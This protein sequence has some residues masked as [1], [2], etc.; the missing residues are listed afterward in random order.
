M[1]QYIN[2]LADKLQISTSDS[3][4]IIWKVFINFCSFVIYIE[5]SLELF[6]VEEFQKDNR[7][8]IF[9]IW[10]IFIL[11]LL[12]IDM[13]I[14]LF[15]EYISNNGII[16]QKPYKKVKYYFRHYF[17]FDLIVIV[18]LFV[19]TFQ[20][21]PFW[22]GFLV[23]FRIPSNLYSDKITE[24]YLIQFQF[25]LLC[26]RILKLL[27]TLLYIF[28]IFACS[29]Y[30]MGLYSISIQEP[31]WLEYSNSVIGNI[32]EMHHVTQYI[33]SY[34]W[35]V[36]TLVS[37]GY[38]EITPMNQYEIIIGD[39]ALV[40]CMFV[41]LYVISTILSFQ[42]DN[43]SYLDENMLSIKQFMIAKRVSKKLY[44]EVSIFLSQ[45][46]IEQSKRDIAIEQVV[47]QRLPNQLKSKLYYEASLKIMKRILWI[48]NNFSNEFIEELSSCVREIYLNANTTISVIDDDD[49]PKIF[50]IDK[51][52]V[53]VIFNEKEINL[54]YR[55][56]TFGNYSFFTQE[57]EQFI[58]Y[59]TKSIVILQYIKLTDFLKTISNHKEDH[60]KFYYIL[61]QVLFEKKYS[62]IQYGCYICTSTNHLSENCQIISIKDQ[63]YEEFYKNPLRNSIQLRKGFIRQ[64]KKHSKWILNRNAIQITHEYPISFDI[65]KRYYSKLLF[66]WHPFSKH[67]QERMNILLKDLLNDSLKQNDIIIMSENK[68][69]N[70]KK[71]SVFSSSNQYLFYWQLFMM[72]VNAIFFIAIP[73][74]IFFWNYYQQFSDQ[75]GFKFIRIIF[76]ILFV[77][78]FIVQLN[79]NFYHEGILVKNRFK[80]AENYLRNDLVFDLIPILVLFYISL[81]DKYVIV[82]LLCLIKLIPFYRFQVYLSDKLKIM[83]QLRQFYMI[84]G[85]LIEILYINHFYGCM[86]YGGSVYMYTYH[87]NSKTWVNDPTMNFGVIITKSTTSKYLYS[88]YWA[89]DAITRIGYGD[90]LP[91]N[92]LEFMITDL[93]VITAV[94][95][96]AVNISLIEN[97]RKN[98]KLQNYFVDNLWIQ[99][100]LKKKNCSDELKTQISKYLRYYHRIG[101][102]RNIDI[103]QESLQLLPSSLKQQLMYE[104][105]GIIFYKQHWLRDDD[106]VLFELSNKVKEIYLGDMENIFLDNIPDQGQA[107]Y[108]VERG[109]VEL[110]INTQYSSRKDVIIAQLKKDTFFGHYSFIT[111]L[112]RKSSARTMQFAS[113]I[114]ILRKD[115]HDVL[116]INKK[117]HHQFQTLRDSIIYENQFQL[118]GLQCFTCNGNDHLSI[119][120]P[121]ISIKKQ[122]LLRFYH[123]IREKSQSGLNLRKL[124]KQNLKQDR[125]FKKRKKMKKSKTLRIHDFEFF[126]DY[127]IPRTTIN[128][129]IDK[130]LH[131]I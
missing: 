65:D 125:R 81:S 58:T 11:S 18:Y 36:E 1:K 38:G 71:S 91:L 62:L 68:S 74:I 22:V 87:P 64:N 52:K 105:Y 28:D 19:S 56:S 119:D 57:K 15:I 30:A 83:P 123:N 106:D 107:L 23:F 126:L 4:L 53:T 77:S 44:N 9:F 113:L 112:P 40:G 8:D 48:Y 92:D 49:D 99:Q 130:D 43:S 108:Y 90:I 102:D 129:V 32:D 131:L 47:I 128:Y 82:Y 98:S 79:T 33:I 13:I 3:V 115:F 66:Q 111:G 93:T 17:V 85:M 109:Y 118:I 55:G 73:Q 59:K 61:D 16:I 121:L 76:I 34:F 94:A 124:Y 96:V 5:I 70:K 24:E 35:A 37:M 7:G 10:R 67:Q 69:K 86:F 6:N 101:Q 63:V 110:F 127:T 26:Y 116:E 45:F 95:I 104:A 103:E 27:V 41:C 100:Y 75:G 50:V 31:T 122:V 120:C 97:M 89:I 114:Y 29:F 12:I 88:T 117:F 80:I 54:L 84:C 21:L 25:L 42:S 51:G 20:P 2:Q 78:D 14:S 46:R 39:L 72:F 60:E